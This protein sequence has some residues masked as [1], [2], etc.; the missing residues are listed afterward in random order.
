[1]NGATLPE[2]AEVLGHKTQQTTQRYAHL[3]ESH[4][5]DVVKSMN[6]KVFGK[7]ANEEVA[8]K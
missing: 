5:H 6:A 8:T 2:I 7:D 1:M 4:V 3:T